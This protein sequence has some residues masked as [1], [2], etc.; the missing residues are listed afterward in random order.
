MKLNHTIQ[1]RPFILKFLFTGRC[2]SLVFLCLWALLLGGCTPSADLTKAKS[3]DIEIWHQGA[4]IS[5]DEF[6]Y[7]QQNWQIQQLAYFISEIQFIAPN[8]QQQPQ[9]KATSWQGENV[10]LIKAQLDDCVVKPDSAIDPST[11]EDSAAK[12]LRLNQQIVFESPVDLQTA[13]ELSFSLGVPFELNHQ[14]PIS[15]PSPL[16]LPSMF[17]SWRTGHKFFRLDLQG[18]NTNWVFHLGSVG[19]EAA[20]VMRSPQ[21]P[22]VQPNRVNLNLKKMH[23]GTKLVLH[24]DRLLTGVALHS[25]NSCLFGPQQKSCELLMSNLI[26]TDVFEWH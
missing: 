7:N 3:I 11:I 5:C 12:L 4:P 24:V 17:W 21:K 20:S 10:V 23:Q 6:Q 18:N 13:K 19:C 8:S 2:V 9:L 1:F 26:Q 14:N 22:C 15:Q 25:G 16:N